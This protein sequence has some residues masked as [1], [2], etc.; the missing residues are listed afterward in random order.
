MLG[1]FRFPTKK[2]TIDAWAKMLEDFTKVAVLAMPVV[3]FGKENTGFKSFAIIAL[4]IFAY[5]GLLF[6]KYF[7]ENINRFITQEE[8]Y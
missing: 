8:E 7:R 1:L 6:A 2:E 3:F 4:I 5:C